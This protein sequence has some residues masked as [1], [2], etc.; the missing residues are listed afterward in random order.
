MLLNSIIPKDALQKRYNTLFR[1]PPKSAWN[2]KCQQKASPFDDA[3]CVF[4]SPT[5]SSWGLENYSFC[6]KISSR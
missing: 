2:P 4:I 1:T 3:S 5:A 6:G